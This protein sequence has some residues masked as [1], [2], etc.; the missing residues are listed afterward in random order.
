MHRSS[1]ASS[2]IELGQCTI[3]GAGVPSDHPPTQT[4]KIVTRSS[5]VIYRHHSVSPAG[6]LPSFSP[7]RPEQKNQMRMPMLVVVA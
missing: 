1:D 4:R 3:G 5:G 6:W 2:T 7:R